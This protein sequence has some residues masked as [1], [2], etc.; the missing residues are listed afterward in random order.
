MA[1]K[2]LR[3]AIGARIGPFR[4]VTQLGEGGFAPVFLASEA[5]G[6]VEVRVVALKL[7]FTEDVGSAVFEQVVAE[8]RSLGRVEHRNVVRYFQIYEDRDAG[9]LALAMEHVRG[10]S[11]SS[12]I[13]T[14]GA[15][16]VPDTLAAGAA[17]AGALS[18][19]HA[20]GLVHRDVKP[21]N[22][23]DAGGI[24]KL[25]D[26]G[27]ATNQR[28]RGVGAPISASQISISQGKTDV[29]IGE[30][31]TLVMGPA[32]G[33]AQQ[34]GAPKWTGAEA[35]LA[36]TVTVDDGSGELI[37]GTM[38]YIDP[39]CLKGAPPDPSS[40]LYALGAMLFECLTGRVPAMP[41]PQSTALHQGIAFGI[42]RPPLVRS[43]A[44]SVPEPIAKL[45][46]ALI[47][48]D[49]ARRPRHA[50]AVLAELERLRRGVGRARSLPP[51]G[52]FRG[53]DA[54]DE[55]HRDVFFGRS[56]DAAQALEALG[57]RGVLALIGPSGSGKSSLARA[58]IVPAVVEGELGGWPPRYE[59]II[60][61]PG[62][63]PRGNVD[64]VFARLFGPGLAGASP[65]AFIATLGARTESSETGIVFYIDALE[66]LVT[67]SQAAESA[68]LAD[69]IARLARAPIPG[70]RVIL[71]ARRDFLDQLLAIPVLGSTLARSVQLVAPLGGRAFAEAVE[72]RLN[73]YGFAL[74]DQAMFEE[75][76]RELD[77]APGAMPLFEF[78]LARLWTER[79]PQTR[80]LPRA[81]LARI[82]GI[83]G[84][85]EQHA[86][87]TLAT[88]TNQHGPD[89]SKIEAVTR[90]VLLSLTTPS[91]T[92]T[93]KT[94]EEIAAFAKADPALVQAARVAF[95]Q[96]RLI[97]AEDGKLTLAHEALLVRWPRLKQWVASVRKERELAEET[98]Q[99][100]VKWRDKKE[101]RGLL[102]R[103]RALREARELLA[104]PT[105]TVSP[106]AHTFV[107]ASRRAERRGITGIVALVASVVI[108]LGTLFVLYQMLERDAR[109]EQKK[110]EQ[111][112]SA[113]KKTGD[114]PESE[115]VKAVKKLLEEKNACERQLEQKR[116]QCPDIIDAGADAEFD[117]H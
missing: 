113:L 104:T 48:P 109:E 53:L 17:I 26:F 117:S 56:I 23:I 13:A 5:Y 46:D 111:F 88:L 97:V 3:P 107:E 12:R 74:E 42:E 6:G 25:I 61:R 50:E 85:L 43:I 66:E 103:G 79:D 96:A 78:A 95:E 32:R 60:M 63:Y 2:K 101:D 21:D 27:I 110:A 7:F 105:T 71:S 54:F 1:D 87:H 72:E 80:R 20:A 29:G 15:L 47:D 37:A 33:T 67:I 52:P 100:A 112:A 57:S 38:G 98:E 59:P 4:L 49:R 18:A 39:E 28:R 82:G 108:G 64:A 116:T 31:R 69:V 9:I 77:G 99:A 16:S 83:M 44:P 51:E 24:F 19:V 68:W 70:V 55:R 115:R 14:N 34:A 90:S 58:A 81:A 102:I 73:V 106:A 30:D 86:E 40:D 75:L 45:V 11:L 65:D 84:A 92:R 93:Q 94:P 114:T 76:A 35:F 22:V 89:G 62:P 36:E 8:A 10:E 91:G 41:T